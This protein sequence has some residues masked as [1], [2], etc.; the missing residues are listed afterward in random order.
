M[1]KGAASAKLSAQ[2]R[3]Q[4]PKVIQA[5]ID[6]SQLSIADAPSGAVPFSFMVMGDTRRLKAG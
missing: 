2:V 5:Q 3:W 1:L 6:Q 4:H